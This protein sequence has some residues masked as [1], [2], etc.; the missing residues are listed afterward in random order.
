MKPLFF[1]M[2]FFC[3]AKQNF[4]QYLEKQN[5]NFNGISF[6][7]IIFKIDS[8]I[9]KHFYVLENDGTKTEK[10]IFESIQGSFFAV[11]AGATD[12]NCD[13]LGLY[14]KEK[15]PLQPLN[16]NNGEGNFYIQPNG[17]IAFLKNEIE[18]KNA[19]K[20]NSSVLY[21]NAIQNG[22]MLISD[23]VINPAFNINSSNKNFRVGVGTFFS[24]NGQFIVFAMSNSPLSFYQFAA[25]FSNKFKCN[26][27][28][29]LEGGDACSM[30]MPTYKKSPSN[31]KK[32]CKYLVVNL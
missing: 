29:V 28:L 32:S 22:P 23:N 5:L 6:D 18:I 4:A 9:S 25:F 21:N 31:I 7:A 24:N 12:V 17:F 11:N 19:S 1:W 27:A 26:N 20:F 3:F 13:L 16:L 8:N 15:N 10:Q 14:I 30:H 2:I